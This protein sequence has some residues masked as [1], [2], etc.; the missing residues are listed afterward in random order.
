MVTT[1]RHSLLHVP[2]GSPSRDRDVAVYVL[3]INQASL[4]PFYSVLVSFFFFS[5]IALSS[6]FRSTNFPDNSPFS[7]S[8]LPVFSLCLIGPFSYISLYVM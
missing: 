8:V 2:A 5:F 3:D 6:V 7:H 4:P 1:Y